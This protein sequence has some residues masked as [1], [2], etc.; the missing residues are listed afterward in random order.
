MKIE[1]VARG[2]LVDAFITFA[3]VC[4]EKGY[5]AQGH[6]TWRQALEA[7]SYSVDRL[8]TREHEISDVILSSV[9]G[10]ELALDE[11]VEAMIEERRG[12]LQDTMREEMDELEAASSPAENVEGIRDAREG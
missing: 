11:Q 4:K 8:G 2:L 7:M 3:A 5:G 9:P 6:V 10:V 12:L 1:D